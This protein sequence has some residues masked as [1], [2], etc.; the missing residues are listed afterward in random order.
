MGLFGA[1]FM[2]IQRKGCIKQLKANIKR[3]MQNI[4]H[5][6]FPNVMNYVAVRMQAVIGQRRDYINHML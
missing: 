5:E 4:P 6:T 1:T 2:Q 3:E